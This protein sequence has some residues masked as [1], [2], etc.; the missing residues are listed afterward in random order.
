VP[1]Y[2]KRPAK[3]TPARLEQL[4]DEGRLLRAEVM[5]W[6]SLGYIHPDN[7]LLA[8]G[9]AR[10]TLRHEGTTLLS[11]FDPVV[12]DRARLLD[13]WGFHYRI[14]VYTPAAKRRYGYFTL[15]ILHRGRLVGRLD[16]KAHR[17]QG[18]LEIRQIHLEADVEPC[19]ELI[20]GLS[21]ALRSFASW[22]DLARVDIGH[23]DPPGLAGAL[24]E[25]LCRVSSHQPSLHTDKQAES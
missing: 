16:P 1:D 3:G 8:R 24:R 11:P 5:S 17:A 15:P 21:G 2:F 22:Q 9:A 12:W 25:E 18:V 6:E 20:E 19:S 23:T 14:E 7:A 4:A 10:G 13:L